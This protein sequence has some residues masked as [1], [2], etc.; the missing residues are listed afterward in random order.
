MIYMMPSAGVSITI[1]SMEMTVEQ[2]SMINSGTNNAHMLMSNKASALFPSSQRVLIDR[3]LPR[4]DA[5]GI[6][7]M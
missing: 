7:D 4:V 3:I 1:K 2:P 6:I 5:R